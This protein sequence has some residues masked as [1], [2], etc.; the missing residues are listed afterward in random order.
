MIG[1]YLPLA[2]AVYRHLRQRHDKV[3][4]TRSIVGSGIQE[5]DP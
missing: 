2:A 5:Q 1:G 3:M 4:V